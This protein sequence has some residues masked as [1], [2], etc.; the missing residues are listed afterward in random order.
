M[1]QGFAIPFS[2]LGA[3]LECRVEKGGSGLAD[4]VE[5]T[6]DED[7]RWSGCCRNLRSLEG[8]EE[9]FVFADVSA[10]AIARKCLLK[11]VAT[12][13]ARAIDGAEMNFLGYR[14]EEG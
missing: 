12:Q 2:L 11:L 14:S 7:W 5:A 13:C 8:G 10:V 4:E 3:G 9:V 1:R 6:S